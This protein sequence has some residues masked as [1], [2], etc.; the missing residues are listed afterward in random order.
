MII[1]ES[2]LLLIW[3]RKVQ[4]KSK[5]ERIKSSGDWREK[6][7]VRNMRTVIFVQDSQAALQLGWG[8]LYSNKAELGIRWGS[9]NMGTLQHQKGITRDDGS[10]HPSP[11]FAF[12]SENFQSLNHF[13]TKST[14]FIIHSH[15]HSCLR[16]EGETGIK[17]DCR[18]R[19]CLISIESS[20]SYH[21]WFQGDIGKTLRRHHESL[22]YG[23]K[24]PQKQ[25]QWLMII[26]LIKFLA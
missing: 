23:N 19:C 8:I 9:A 12:S 4:E 2:I 17:P 13:S 25:L 24:Y 3:A 21:N 18:G 20:H 11:F 5:Q 16:Q 26:L 22:C 1:P 6:K 15:Q 7:L 14:G 10:S